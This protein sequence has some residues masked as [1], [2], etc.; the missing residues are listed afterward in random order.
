MSLFCYI[1][2]PR[3]KTATATV[4]GKSEKILLYNQTKRE[5]S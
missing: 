1:T 2:K 3:E 5:G 4:N